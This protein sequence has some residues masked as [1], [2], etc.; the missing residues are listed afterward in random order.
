VSAFGE[1]VGIDADGNALAIWH[2]FEG[3]PDT[4]FVTNVYARRFAPGAGWGV[5]YPLIEGPR[6]PQLAINARG[7]AVVAWTTDVLNACALE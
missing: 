4:G 1:T 7:D 3:S 5:E 6:D 2:E